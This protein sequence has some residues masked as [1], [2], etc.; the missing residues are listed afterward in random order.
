VVTTIDP[1]LIEATG[2]DGIIEAV[3]AWA[4]ERYGR[5]DLAAFLTDEATA[6]ALLAASDKLAAG[7][8]A[9]ARG[10]LIVSRVPAALAAFVPAA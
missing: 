1:S 10:A 9:L 6:R 7:R 5:C 2:R 4:E 3:I 8:E